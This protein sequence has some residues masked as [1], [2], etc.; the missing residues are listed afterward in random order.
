[1]YPLQG[2]DS[3]NLERPHKLMLWTRGPHLMTQFKKG[4]NFA[5][6]APWLAEVSH[7]RLALRVT[8][9]CPFRLAFSSTEAPIQRT[10]DCMASDGSVFSTR[11]AM[12]IESKTGSREIWKMRLRQEAGNCM[13]PFTTRKLD[14]QD[15]AEGA[16]RKIHSSECLHQSSLMSQIT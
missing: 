7:W 14:P 1:M 8:A 16:L 2:P 5:C 9:A 4:V 3:S 12:R 6:H 13:L 15:T 11:F 10:P